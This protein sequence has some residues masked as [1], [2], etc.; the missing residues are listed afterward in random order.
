MFWQC[1]ALQTWLVLELNGAWLDQFVSISLCLAVLVLSR[2]VKFQFFFSRRSDEYQWIKIG[3]FKSTLCKLYPCWRMYV[4]E[5]GRPLSNHILLKRK[6]SRF[7]VVK[8]SYCSQGQSIESIKSIML[9]ICSI[10]LKLYIS[11][12]V[13]RYIVIDGMVIHYYA[14]IKLQV[15]ISFSFP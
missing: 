11:L 15:H 13:K 6:F 9:Q 2:E 8:W 1:L 10:I 7:I 12:Q 4:I 5:F 14:D 3:I